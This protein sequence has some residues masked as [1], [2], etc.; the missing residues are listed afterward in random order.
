MKRSPPS[1]LQDGR[2]AEKRPQVRVNWKKR[3]VPPSLQ[4][5]QQIKRRPRGGRSKEG[6]TSRGESSTAESR[7]SPGEE[8]RKTSP[9][10]LRS[11]ARASKRQ[12]ESGKTS[13]YPL[14]SRAG[15]MMSR[16]EEAATQ[17]AGRDEQGHIY[18]LRR[19][20]DYRKLG[21]ASKAKKKFM[22]EQFARR[23]SQTSASVEVLSGDPTGSL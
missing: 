21:F 9:Y 18:N 17:R 20:E 3:T 16:G 8:I 15:S 1:S 14:R 13:P 10:P 22:M 5:R 2:S 12:E 7:K 6:L 11:R 23:K 19:R 4:S